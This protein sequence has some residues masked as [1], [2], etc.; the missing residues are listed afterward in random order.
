[1]ALVN[2][3]NMVGQFV[4]M[5]NLPVI[6]QIGLLLGLAASIALG[7]G[8]YSWAKEPNYVPLFDGMSGADAAQVVTILEQGNT[9]YRMQGSMV[10][11]P[12]GKVHNLR[13]QLA[14]QGL[15]KSSSPGYELLDEEQ[16]F[17]TSSFVEKARFNRALEGELSRSIATLNSVKGARVHLAIPKKSAF[18]RNQ[19]GASA[20]VLI[21][22]FPGRKLNQAQVAGVIHLVAS[23]VPGMDSEQVTVVDQQGNLLTG[24][25]GSSAMAMG[26]EQFSFASSIEENYSQRIV[27]LLVPIMGAGKVRAQVTADVDFTAVERTSETFG[28]NNQLVRSEQTSEERRSDNS[29]AFGGV[30]GA[31]SNQPAAALG[32]DDAA[33]GNSSAAT[34]TSRNATRNYE[35]DKVI[36]HVK[37]APGNIKKLSVAVLLDHRQQ[38][39]EA[40]DIERLPLPD[41]EIERLTL[42]VKE[43]VGFNEERGDSVNLMNASFLEPELMEPLAEV[44]VWQEPWVLDIAKQVAGGIGILVLV[45]GILRPVMKSLAGFGK[46]GGR[47]VNG[48]LQL[49]GDQAAVGGV[50]QLP[51][52]VTSYDQQVQL[53]QNIAGQSPKRA[54]SVMSDWVQD[55][56]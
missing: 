31:Q 25:G 1:M 51:P 32:G 23:S 13:I 12:A 27:D 14:S 40:G 41:E 48:E 26:S 52:G 37:E 42:L 17:G 50:A 29:K 54:A 6:R 21:S 9:P 24:S 15:P 45:F 11:V 36:S 53:A 38:T 3:D 33:S 16:S 34:Q 20:S 43:A 46:S 7:V 49:G 19:Q 35:L 28:P 30:P 22:L 10:A 44:P 39:N 18:L 2:P 5:S 56:G 8:I 4:G 47:T 55:G